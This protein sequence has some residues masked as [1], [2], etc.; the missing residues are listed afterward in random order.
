[1]NTAGIA[2]GSTDDVGRQGSLR[3]LGADEC[4]R[5]HTFRPHTF[6]SG[7]GEPAVLILR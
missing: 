3:L 1:M 6:I 2:H 5:P 4:V 7:R